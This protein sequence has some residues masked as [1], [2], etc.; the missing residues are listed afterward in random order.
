MP[1]TYFTSEEAREKIGHLVEA[2]A[3]FPSVLQ[4]SRGRVVKARRYSVNQW[5]TCIEWELPQAVSHYEMTFGDASLNFFRQ[6]KPVTD[7]FCKSEY[8]TLL[9]VIHDSN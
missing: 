8:E 6:S 5:L 9:S 3:D 4:G 7:Q 2:R 1:R